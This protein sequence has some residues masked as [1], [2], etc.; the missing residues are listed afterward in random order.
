M[1]RL[2]P[3]TLPSQKT[4]RQ[5]PECGPPNQELTLDD[6]WSEGSASPRKVLPLG[7]ARGKVLSWKPAHRLALF[8]LP[9]VKTLRSSF[10]PRNEFGRMCFSPNIS[11]LLV[12]SRTVVRVMI[13]RLF[14]IRVP[15]TV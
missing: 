10:L 1:V 9:L 11:V 14:K 8:V 15:E 2:R 3:L 6:S 13:P 4:N 12:P 5:M 7:L